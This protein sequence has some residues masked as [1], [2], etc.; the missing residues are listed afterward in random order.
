MEKV[1]RRNR[2]RY[3]RCKHMTLQEQHKYKLFC[4]RLCRLLTNAYWQTMPMFP[5]SEEYK[6]YEEWCEHCRDLLGV[7]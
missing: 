6:K 1:Y 4:Q 2:D 7:N 5:T 3:E